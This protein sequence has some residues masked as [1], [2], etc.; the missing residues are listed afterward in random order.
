MEDYRAKAEEVLNNVPGFDAAEMK[1]Y[2]NYII[3]E[4]TRISESE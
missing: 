1:T 4:F 3:A 2:L